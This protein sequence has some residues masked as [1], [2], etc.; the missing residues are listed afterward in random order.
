SLMASAL[1]WLLASFVVS[2]ALFPPFI[3]FLRESGVLTFHWL[4]PDADNP[5]FFNLHQKKIGTPSMGGAVMVAVI[6]VATPFVLSGPTLLAFHVALIPLALL[7]LADDVTKVLV[8]SGRLTRDMAARPKLVAQ[9]LTGLGV[10]GI[11]YL[12]GVQSVRVPFGLSLDLGIIYVLAAAFVV[13]ASA[14]AVNIADGLDG[15]AG[16]LLVIALSA[17][18]VLATI[19]QRYD[20]MAISAVMTGAILGFL[21]FNIHPAKVFMGDI[22]SLALGGTLGTLALL[23]D[24]WVPFAIIAGVL[25]VE[26]LSSLIQTIAL[27]RGRRVF[28][29]APL[30]HHFEAIGWPEARITPIF[31]LAGALLAYLGILVA[32]L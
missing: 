1:L 8:R 32:L 28:R 25:V 5:T 17:F 23:L 2:A 30:H 22:G 3:R 18:M 24:H 4:R 13:A 6:A 9:W 10:A 21:A 11:L 15:L 27:R 20:L 12:N 14:N 26:T 16:G 7:G 31:W 29:I 19:Q